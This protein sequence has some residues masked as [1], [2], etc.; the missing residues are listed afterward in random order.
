MY[1]RLERL[2]AGAPMSRVRVLTAISLVAVV[3]IGLG[4]KF[5][6]GPAQA[7][8]ND[9]SSSL[10]YECFWMLAVFFLVPR[11]SAI[12]RIALGVF[13]ATCVIEFSQLWH[14]PPLEA[15]RR[16]FVGRLVLGTTFD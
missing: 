14:P 6:R 13:L 10:A 2:L 11:R 9:W 1:G 7:F 4:L 16:T 8:V 5:Y 12:A 3:P 15:V